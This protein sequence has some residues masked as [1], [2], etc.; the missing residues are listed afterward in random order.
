MNMY[1]LDVLTVLSTCYV[2][3]EIKV[4]FIK[5]MIKFPSLNSQ[6][7]LV[8]TGVLGWIAPL[9]NSQGPQLT[10]ISAF[11]VFNDQKKMNESICQDYDCH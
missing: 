6:L 11:K 7:W 5:T 1:Q 8:A 4:M 10:K 3:Q 2:R 9:M